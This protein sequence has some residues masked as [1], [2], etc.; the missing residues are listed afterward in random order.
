LA[1][2]QRLVGRTVEVTHASPRPGD[3]RFS[4]ISAERISR[5]LGWAAQDTLEEGLRE[6]L[7]TLES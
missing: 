7:V 6:I 1:E 2:V 4:S 5:E 3:V